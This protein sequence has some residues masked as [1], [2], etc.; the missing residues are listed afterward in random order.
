MIEAM[1]AGV[2]VQD[3]LCPGGI[4]AVLALPAVGRGQAAGRRPDA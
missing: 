4:P 3:V 1:R 2:Q